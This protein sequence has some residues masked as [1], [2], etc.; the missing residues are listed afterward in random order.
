M[1]IFLMLMLAAMPAAADWGRAEGTAAAGLNAARAEVQI[2]GGAPLLDLLA[3]RDAAAMPLTIGGRQFLA[4]VVFDADWESWFSL[5]PAADPLA[6]NAW[7]E[8]DLASGAVYKYK[9]L[10]IKLKETDGTVAVESS[11]GEKLQVSVNALFDLV[12][13]KSRKVTFGEIVTYAVFRNLEPLSQTEGTVSLRVGSDGLYYFS[14]TPDSQIEAAPRWLLA[15]NGVLYG[16]RVDQGSLLF[17]S[18]VIE[19]NKPSPA[20]AG[21]KTRAR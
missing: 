14:V 5:K 15:V 11:S 10:T 3:A 17:V 1:K 20:L 8:S 9:D 7:K 2:I 6:A 12:Y 4:T 18:K 16:L 13:E 21:E 19:M